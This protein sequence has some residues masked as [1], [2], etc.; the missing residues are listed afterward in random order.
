KSL[1]QHA[2][3]DLVPNMLFQPVATKFLDKILRDPIGIKNLNAH[4]LKLK[5]ASHNLW[6]SSPHIPECHHFFLFSARSLFQQL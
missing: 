4:R 2:Y 1:G 6:L 5:L 3:A